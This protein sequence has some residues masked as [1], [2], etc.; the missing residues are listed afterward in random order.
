MI[1]SLVYQPVDINGL[2]VVF[3]IE[4]GQESILIAQRLEDGGLIKSAYAFLVYNIFTGGYDR[5]RAGQYQLSPAD[6]I[7]EISRKIVSER[8]LPE[9]VVTIPGGLN[10]RQWQERLEDYF[11]ELDLASYRIA[12]FSHDFD[13]LAD[14]PAEATLEGYLFPD[15]YHFNRQTDPEVMVRTFLVNFE[16]RLADLLIQA[17]EQNKNIHHLVILASLIEREVREW[18]DKRLVAG[19]IERRR[20]IG[21]PLQIDATITYLTGRASTAITISETKIDS[22]YNTYLY[23]GLPIG[24]ICHPGRLSFQAVMDPKESDYLFYLSTPEGETI[25]SRTLEEHNRAKAKYLR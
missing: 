8:P 7:A 3:E 25:F 1:W 17:K 13:F 15:T 10:L 14:A 22:S 6:N 19:L 2:E 16:R 20:S 23:P 24:P 12:D 4:P 11:P 9:V 21:M 5:L 18:A